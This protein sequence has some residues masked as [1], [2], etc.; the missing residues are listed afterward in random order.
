MNARL[1]GESPTTGQWE[2]AQVIPRRSARDLR[3]LDIPAAP[4]V[5]I[6]FRDNEPVYVGEARG[7]QGLRGRLRA[8]R[9]TSPDLSRSTFRASVA[10]ANL[11][12][13]R[14]T[15]R[16]RPTVMTREQVSVVNTWIDACEL[17]WIVCES[18]DEAHALEK[19]LRAE[20][21]PP[22]NRA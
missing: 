11:S 7:Q 3:L 21:L 18:A 13:D 1:Y 9:S 22:L 5:Y 16:L 17:A 2:L 8:H 15:A 12:I 14:R 6:W 4:G 10:V 19:A 20:W